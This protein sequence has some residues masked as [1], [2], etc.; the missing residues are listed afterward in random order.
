MYC[1]SA[2]SSVHGIFQA[3]ILEWVAI[4]FSSDLPDPGIKPVSPALSGV[5]LHSFLSVTQSNSPI[6]VK[7][8][9]AYRELDQAAG[10]AAA[11]GLSQATA[12]RE[13]NTHKSASGE[14]RSS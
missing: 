9:A 12:F 1:N 11:R 8:P 14:I 7:A 10:R 6:S 3:R 5:L 2:G 13:S 4:S